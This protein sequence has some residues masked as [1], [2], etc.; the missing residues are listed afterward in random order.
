MSDASQIDRRGDRRPPPCRRSRCASASFHNMVRVMRGLRCPV[1]KRRSEAVSRKLT[2]VHAAEHGRQASCRI[3]VCHTFGHERLGRAAILQFRHRTER[4][5]SAEADKE[6]RDAAVR[7]FMRA[8]GMVQVRA[9]RSTSSHLRAAHLTAANARLGPGIP[10]HW[11]RSCSVSRSSAMK[12][13]AS[14]QSIAAWCATARTL[15]LAGSISCR[16]PR[17]TAGLGPSRQPRAM[18]S[19]S[20]LLDPAT[21]ARL[22]VSG[23]TRPDRVKRPQYLFGRD[24]LG[25]PAHR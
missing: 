24:C 9:S 10:V 20:T 25:P 6:E 3:A 22:A 12:A 21:Q 18:A 13:G 23:L 17:H 16:W 7:A 1:A 8:A 15:P 4:I 14:R 19:D 5:P 2:A 11:H